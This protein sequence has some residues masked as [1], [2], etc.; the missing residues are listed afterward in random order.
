MSS[1]V[2]GYYKIAVFKLQKTSAKTTFSMVIPFRNEAENLPILLE[3]LFKQEYPEA[4]YEVLFVND[5][6][7]D[8]SVKMIEDFISDKKRNRW[9]VLDNQ[10]KSLSPK[11][12]AI[13]TAILN[14]KM[15]WILTTDADCYAFK[16]HLSAFDSFIQKTHAVMVAA[17]VVF[18]PQNKNSILQHLQVQEALSL[19]TAAIG[20]FGLKSPFL[21]NGAN[22]AYQKKAFAEVDGFLGNDQMA[23]GDDVFLLQKI[24]QKFPRKVHFLKS[25]EAV[26]YTQTETSW[27]KMIQQRVRW[28]A[29]TTAYENVFPKVLGVII[30][31]MNLCIPVSLF[32]LPQWWWIAGI[33]LL[34]LLIDSTLMLQSAY[35]FK[36]KFHF[37]YFFINSLLYPFLMMMIIFKSLFGKYQ[38]KGRSF[39]K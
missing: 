14:S 1:L 32:L 39:K 16:N 33:F 27:K 17:P 10:R 5:D 31:I 30:F 35:F 34:K 29:K 38:W 9:K 23:S 22:L 21:C 36:I 3:S 8:E 26:V 7:A 4:L 19:T 25:R 2:L 20:G 24:H 37:F 12:D 15:D 28:T 13:T 18:V 6:S 11:K